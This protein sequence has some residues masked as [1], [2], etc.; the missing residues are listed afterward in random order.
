M[1]PV[2][3]VFLFLIFPVPRPLD[4]VEEEY[5]EAVSKVTLQHI[6]RDLEPSTSYTFYV[7]AYTSH[8]ASKPSDGATETTHGEGELSENMHVAASKQDSRVQNTAWA[9]ANQQRCR[10]FPAR[11]CHADAV[12]DALCRV[13]VPAPPLLHM[14]VLNSSVIQA[15]WEP[16]SKMGQHQGYRLYYKGAQTALF[17]G[18][19]V[20]PRNTSQYIITQLGELLFLKSPLSRS[21]QSGGAPTQGAASLLLRFKGFRHLIQNFNPVY[22]L[23]IFPSVIRSFSRLRDQ[24]AGLQPTR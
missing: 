10:S 14:K 4:P 24:A 16:S 1:L 9:C 11:R 7:K 13:A 3:F 2:L 21:A 18:P 22:F 20:L 23:R 6:I 5:E 15:S 19:I 12:L 8:G 17:I